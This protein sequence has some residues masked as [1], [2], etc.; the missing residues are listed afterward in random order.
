MSDE[1]PNLMTM[2]MKAGMTSDEFKNSLLRSLRSVA[3]ADILI[4]IANEGIDKAPSTLTA[5]L[6]ST[7]L[8]RVVISVEFDDISRIS[9][10]NPPAFH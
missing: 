10:D 7:M 2:A 9:G 5:I 3:A 1:K 4:Q 8:G 6:D